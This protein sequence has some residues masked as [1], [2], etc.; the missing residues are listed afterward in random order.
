MNGVKVY[1][2]RLPDGVSARIC[3]FLSPPAC[4]NSDALALHD[5]T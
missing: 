1:E 4:T 3:S 2:A 5:D